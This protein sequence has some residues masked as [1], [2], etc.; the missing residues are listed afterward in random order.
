MGKTFPRGGGFIPH[1]KG[2]TKDS[3][4]VV[5]PAPREIVIP[6]QQHI[7]APCKPTVHVGDQVRLGQKIGE[8]T[9]YVQAPVHASVS[10]QVV[11]VEERLLLTGEPCLSI[12][13]ANDNLD[14]RKDTEGYLLAKTSGDQIR[15]SVKESG[16]VG[17]GG[18][19]F[20]THVKLAVPKPIDTIIVN[21]AECEPYLTCDHRLMVE[22]G[23]AL[24]FGLQVMMKATGATRGIFGI[25]TN[26]MDAISHLENLVKEDPSL[27]VVPLAVRYPQGA[28]K[29]LIKAAVN[30]EV[31]S[32]ML[33]FE[34]GCLVSN[35]HTVFSL[36]CA[37]QSGRPLYQRVITVSGGRILN[38]SNLLV[39]I[40]TP[41]QDVI[42]FC[43]GYYSEPEVLVAGGPMTGVA[44]LDPRA[45]V[46]K[47]VSGLLALGS[48]E[49]S[50]DENRPCIRC[51]RCVDACPMG[52]SPLDI[53]EAARKG[54]GD[55]VDKLHGMDCIECALCSYTCPAKR[56]LVSLI[57]E[58][59]RE[60]VSK[61]AKG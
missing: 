9:S 2:A 11:A 46:T 15:D 23:E 39:R 41:I 52:L 53:A 18:A 61:K 5:M 13:I 56:A 26:K 1:R 54:R 31:P 37:F 33:P 42:E 24:V 19:G 51:A 20:P 48:D 35:V 44:V 55:E 49:V 34:V 21:G 28:E 14:T 3:P 60:L 43:G 58:G 22:R 38:P 36:A 8:S 7:G 57:R 29:Q 10:G 12:V 30:R 27:R 59:K 4:I 16:I 6:M 32:G 45:P 17:M 25:E 40:G 50:F 47:T